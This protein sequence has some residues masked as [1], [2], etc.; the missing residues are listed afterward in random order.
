[1]HHHHGAGMDLEF[2]LLGGDDLITTTAHGAG[3]VTTE[4]LV[5]R[6]ARQQAAA[7]A[8][9]YECSFVLGGSKIWDASS[10]GVH[11]WRTGVDYIGSEPGAI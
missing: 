5:S 3:T 8:F 11:S 2:D 7:D 9:A 6:A 4:Q 1:M 10:I